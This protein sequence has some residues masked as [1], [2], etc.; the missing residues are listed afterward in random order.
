M[1]LHILGRSS[2]YPSGGRATSS[3]MLETALGGMLVDCGHDAPSKLVEQYTLHDLTAVI[4]SHMH[5]DHFYG[6]FSLCNR[7]LAARTRRLALHLPPGGGAVIRDMSQAMGF[8][9]DT[10]R[11]CF[12]S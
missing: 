5:P 3:Y 8:E 1:K 11:D 6:L 10:I 2:V 9:Y 12:H 7:L 4:I